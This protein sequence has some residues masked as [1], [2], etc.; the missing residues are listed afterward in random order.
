[1]NDYRA[2]SNDTDREKRRI[3]RR[4]CPTATLSNTN[5]TRKFS[6]GVLETNLKKIQYECAACGFKWLGIRPTAGIVMV[7]VMKMDI[8]RAVQ[9]RP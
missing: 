8:I 6:C 9:G 1:V 4:I 7:M 5:T 3:R 2:L